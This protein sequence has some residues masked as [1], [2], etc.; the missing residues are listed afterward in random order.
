LQ[1]I[2]L[3]PCLAPP[4]DA[5][6]SMLPVCDLASIITAMPGSNVLSGVITSSPLLIIP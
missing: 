2:N 3:L 6:L 1:F 4:N 5:T